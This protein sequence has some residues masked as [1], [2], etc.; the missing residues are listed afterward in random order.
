MVSTLASAD[1]L[2]LTGLVDVFVLSEVVDVCVA[3]VPE[4]LA[5]GSWSGLGTVS[6]STDLLVGWGCCCEIELLVDGCSSS[7]FSSWPHTPPCTYLSIDTAL[8]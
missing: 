4:L 1:G 5:D 6:E 7:E 3:S 2:S 8:I